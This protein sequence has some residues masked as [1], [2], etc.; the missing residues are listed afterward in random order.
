MM[1]NS[2]KTT[3]SKWAEDLNKHFF[4]EEYRWQQAHEKVF[5]VA[6][7]ERNASQNHNEISPHSSQNGYHEKI[8]KQ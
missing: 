5:H 1:L 7:Y 2:I 4:K 3:H 8:H 6:N